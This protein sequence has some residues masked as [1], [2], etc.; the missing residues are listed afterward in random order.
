MIV[1]IVKGIKIRCK[2]Y[3]RFLGALGI[4]EKKEEEQITEIGHR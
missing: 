4:K 1:K 3:N 2:G